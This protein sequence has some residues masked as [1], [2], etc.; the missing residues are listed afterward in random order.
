MNAMNLFSIRIAV[1]CIV[2]D[3]VVPEDGYTQDVQ[4]H[5]VEAYNFDEAFVK[6]LAIGKAQEQSYKNDEG[7]NVVWRFK[8]VENI[9]KIGDVATGVEI[10]T[11]FEEFFPQSP[12]NVN[13]KFS[14]EKSE[15]IIDDESSE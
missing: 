3:G 14:P 5:L 10:S 6:A 1:I 12:L 7:N 15:P 11:R 4:V 9:R 13:S 8:D 2:D